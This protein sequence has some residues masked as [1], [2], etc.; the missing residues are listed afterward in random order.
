[1]EA[2]AGFVI[3]VALTLFTLSKFGRIHVHLDIH[4][5]DDDGPDDDDGGPDDVDPDVWPNGRRFVRRN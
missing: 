1:M 5:H 3:G 2:F 4:T